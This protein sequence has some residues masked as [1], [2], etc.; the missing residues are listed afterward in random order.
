MCV[1]PHVLRVIDWFQV[2]NH[3][4]FPVSRRSR[5]QVDDLGFRN[6]RINSEAC[7]I[8]PVLGTVEDVAIGRS[9]DLVGLAENAIEGRGR[10]DFPVPPAFSSNCSE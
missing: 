9:Y 10:F 3:V 6:S 1:L 2:A 7:H 5:W 8:E 4:P